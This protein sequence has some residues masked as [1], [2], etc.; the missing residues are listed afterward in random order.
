M[1]HPIRIGRMGTLAVGLSIGAALASTPQVASADPP[2]DPL[3]WADQVLSSLPVPAA[4]AAAPLDMQISISG[5][6]LFS[7]VGNTATATS[8]FGDI[9]IAMGDG[10]NATATGFGDLSFADGIGSTASTGLGGLFDVAIANGAGSNAS[11]GVAGN[12]VLASAFGDHSTAG[13]GLGGNFVIASANGVG[14]TA[15]AGVGSNFDIA[16]AVGPGSQATVGIGGGLDTAFANGAN[17]AANAG[18]GQGN[19]AIALGADSN[20]LAG[21][22]NNDLATAINGGDATA[23]GFQSIAFADGANSDAQTAG[24]GDIASIINTGS[25]FDQAFSGGTS[26]IPFSDNDLAMIIGTDSTAI[27]GSSATTAGDWDFAGVFGDML[28]ANATGANF[29]FDI[30]PSL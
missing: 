24:I 26:A 22:G 5:M 6:D 29:L 1:S 16:S 4:D 3:S 11:G 9:A 25:G 7:T 15:G 12:F 18:V 20:A 21:V 27:A 28:H 19:N 14:S 17:S 23:G 10:A 2:A 30:L 8:G 13:A